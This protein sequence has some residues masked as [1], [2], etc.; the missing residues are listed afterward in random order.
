MI[1]NIYGLRIRGE[2]L[3]FYIG[4]TSNPLRI[5]LAGHIKDAR[6]KKSVNGRKDTIINNSPSDIEIVVIKELVCPF[7]EATVEE[8]KVIL[9]Y[10][11][12]G[13]PL[14]NILERR[15]LLYG[16]PCTKKVPL[17]TSSKILDFFRSEAN[18]KNT[19]I[20]SEIN[21]ALVQYKNKF[22]K[23]INKTKK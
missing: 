14:V 15:K 10:I 16:N 17:R 11:D 7:T 6:A 23:S 3:F 8:N 21:I 18:R 12:N 4:V 5:R 22:K 13:H 19:S 2:Q 1:H 9:E 20:N